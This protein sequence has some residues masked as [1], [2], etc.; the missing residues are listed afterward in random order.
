MIEK[1]KTIAINAVKR[2]PR[3][4]SSNVSWTLLIYIAWRNMV[5]KK[6][7]TFLTI[8]GIVIGIGAIFFLLSFGLGLQNLV[9][10]QVVGNQSIKS[11]D[12][13]TPNSRL[14]KLDKASIER[15]KGLPHVEK[16][17]TQFSFPGSLKHNNSELDTVTYGV[18]KGYLDLTDLSLSSGRQ[19]ESSDNRSMMINQAARTALGYKNDK[20][21]IG[22]KIKLYIPLKSSSSD[23]ASIEDDFT[24]VGVVDS[25]SGSEVFIPGFILENAGVQIY[26]QLKLTADKTE[27]VAD[28]R[29]QIQTFGFETSSPSDTIEQINQIFKFFNIVLFGFGAIGMI[30]A[31]LGM[32]NTLTI[33]LIE[34]TKEIGLMMALGARSTDMSRLFIFEAA[35]LS[36]VGASIGILFAIIS[37]FIVNIIMNAFA[38]SRGVTDTFDL[39]ATPIWLILA[40]ILF[41]LIVG[42]VVAFFPAK[43]AKRISAIDSLRR[44]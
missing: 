27:N 41:M 20:D 8:F 31:V 12:V 17:G 16:S 10:R 39:F 11:V 38:R 14:I 7:R 40:L 15:I 4:Q 44:E 35:L 3:R 34:R 28:L 42:L 37:G 13:S 29:K 43:R 5:S 22:Q 36:V 9:T 32:F 2:L 6:L 21:A 23:L 18:D 25:G 19:L 33:S 30:V 1:L 26:S 24:I